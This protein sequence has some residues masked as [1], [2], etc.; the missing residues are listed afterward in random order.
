MLLEDAQQHRP[1]LGRD[2]VRR[3]RVAHDP[4][5]LAVVRLPEQMN[6]RQ[7]YLA[8]TKIAR[9]RLAD[10]LRVAR[11][12]EQV[13]YQLE[14]DP[15]IEAVLTKGLLAIAADLAQHAADLRAAAEQVRRLAAHDVEML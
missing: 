9:E 2:A 3:D 4:R 5:S 7:R 6:E 11:E 12:V 8:F 10:R 15:E 1:L 13:V 14:G